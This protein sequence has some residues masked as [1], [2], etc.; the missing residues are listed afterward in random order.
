VTR[1]KTLDFEERTMEVA[2]MMSNE[3]ITESALE[4]ARQLLESAK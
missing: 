2:R 4:N 3:K 1:V